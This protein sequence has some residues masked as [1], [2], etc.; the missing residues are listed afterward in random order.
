MSNAAI[1]VE[2]MLQFALKQ[3]EIATMFRNAQG[4]DIT[5]AQVADSA[6]SRDV[7]IMKAEKAVEGTLSDG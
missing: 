7:A 3:Q 6:V 4:G 2:L 5:D 1:L